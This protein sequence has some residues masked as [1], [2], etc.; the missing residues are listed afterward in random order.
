M[1]LSHALKASSAAFCN[2]SCT[3]CRRVN[4]GMAV[5]LVWMTPFAHPH[6]QY[7]STT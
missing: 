1:Y 2:T 3:G 5:L 6:S 7:F 4:C